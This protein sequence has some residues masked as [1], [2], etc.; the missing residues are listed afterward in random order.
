MGGLWGS[1]LGE[2]QANR[3]SSKTHNTFACLLLVCVRLAC[4]SRP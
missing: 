3:E 1:G 2:M 4:Q